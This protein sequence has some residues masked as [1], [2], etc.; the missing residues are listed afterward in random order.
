MNDFKGCS[1]HARSTEKVWVYLRAIT[2]LTH[3]SEPCKYEQHIT[4]CLD[5]EFSDKL[6][7]TP[8]FQHK[9]K[10][11][12]KNYINKSL[13]RKII[14]KL[15]C[16]TDST[17]NTKLILTQFYF[18]S[19]T[20]ALPKRPLKKKQKEIPGVLDKPQLDNMP[21][22][23]VGFNPFILQRRKEK[24]RKEEWVSKAQM[25]ESTKIWL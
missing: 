8:I 18:F 12:I 11:K 15:S 22:K 20:S 2:N 13:I 14:S 3:N 16:F 10:E 4:A 19:S 7:N 21:L 1:H 9:E 5:R 17:N 25:Q 24:I 23:I 6:R